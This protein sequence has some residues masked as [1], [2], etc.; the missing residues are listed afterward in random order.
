MAAAIPFIAAAAAGIGAISSIKN[1]IDPEKPPTPAAA[2]PT[3]TINDAQ[4]QSDEESSVNQRQGALANLLQPT[5]G[6]MS[7]NANTSL[8][9]LLGG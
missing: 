1:L 9:S 6:A 5:A 2:P 3:P 7:S 4:R 8:R